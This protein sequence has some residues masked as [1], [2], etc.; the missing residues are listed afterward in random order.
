MKTRVLSLNWFDFLEHEN[1][2]DDNNLRRRLNRRTS[3]GKYDTIIASDVAYDSSSILA[4]SRTLTAL[5][6][7]EK[8]KHPLDIKPTQIHIFGPSNRASLQD[9]IAILRNE[10]NFTTHVEFLFIERL[11]LK[12]SSSNGS[13]TPGLDKRNVVSKKMVEFVHV[14]VSN[15][16]CRDGSNGDVS[17]SLVD[18]D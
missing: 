5:L 13:P 18:L 1:K 4:L 12:A 2:E 10:P 8:G 7:N 3:V 9:L 15:R 6:R 11:R 17:P 14:M 16:D